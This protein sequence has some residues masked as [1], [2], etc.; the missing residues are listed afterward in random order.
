MSGQRAATALLAGLAGSCA[1]AAGAAGVAGAANQARLDR[2]ATPLTYDVTAVDPRHHVTRAAFV[3]L[4]QRS[5]RIWEAP[6]GRDLLRYEPGGTTKVNLVFD[7][8]QVQENRVEAADAAIERARAELASLKAELRRRSAPLDA[9]KRRYA[10]KVA[11]WNGQGGAPAGV[12]DT[13]RAEQT[14]INA[15]VEEFN[16]LTHDYNALV[17]RFNRNVVARNALAQPRTTDDEVLGKA[18]VGGGAVWIYVLTGTVK[19]DALIAHEFGHILGIGHLPGPD[20]V[21]NAKRVKT[22]TRASAAD[23]AALR[24]ACAAG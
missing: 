19:D 1:V 3:A 15:L 6:L 21:M 2:C 24:A 5:E 20:D 17:A 14:A 22:L 9:R 10:A 8:R 23:L 7:W 12:G 16:T 4:L 18:E 11:Y 13:L